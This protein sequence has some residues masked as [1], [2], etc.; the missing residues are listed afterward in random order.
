MLK[1]GFLGVSVSLVFKQFRGVGWGGT[2]LVRQLKVLQT[3]TL[4]LLVPAISTVL[5]RPIPSPTSGGTYWQLQ[6]LCLH[7]GLSLPLPEQTT[8]TSCN[9]HLNEGAWLAG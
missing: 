7:P 3:H 1:M 5:A 2:V 9:T 6:L 4:N 8:L